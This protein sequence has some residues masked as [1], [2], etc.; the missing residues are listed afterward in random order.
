MSFIL[1]KKDRQIGG[2]FYYRFIKGLPLS[3]LLG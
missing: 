3:L 2:L 1:D